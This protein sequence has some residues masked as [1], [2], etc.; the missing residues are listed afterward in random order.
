LAG[1]LAALAMPP[2]YGCRSAWWV[3][4]PSSGSGTAH[5]RRERAVA[6][7]GWGIGHFASA[8]YWIVERSSSRRPSFALVGRR[9]F[10]PRACWVLSG[11]A[12]VAPRIATWLV[13][14]GRIRRRLCVLAIAWTLAEWLRGHVFTGFPW[15]PLGHVWAFATPIATRAPVVASMALAP[16]V[17]WCS[18]PPA[19][20]G[21]SGVALVAVWRWGARQ[22]MSMR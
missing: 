20:G 9:W 2:L 3:W 6:R 15:N 13:L 16:L 22:T 11:D 4:W 17:F 1:A 18:P 14:G 7:L 10:G 12:R 8:S 19:G 5:R 21:P